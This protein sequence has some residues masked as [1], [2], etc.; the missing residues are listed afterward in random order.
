MDYSKTLQLPTT[1]FPMRASLP[2]REPVILA[3]WESENI[4]LRVQEKNRGR[5]KF[6]LH[7]GPP[8]A[9]GNIHLGT[10]LNK[11][12]KDIVVKFK[13]MDGFDAPY[14]PGWDTHGLPIEHAVI[15]ATGANPNE[16]GTVTFRQKCRD[17]ALK[18]RDIQ[19]EEFRR[20]GV[21]GDWDNPYMT[22]HPEFEA[23]QIEVFG[24]MAKK[25]YI[26]KGLK[27]VY[28]CA[29][30]ETALAEA[31]VEYGDR[32]S[33]SIFV[34]FAFPDG[35]RLI[36][37]ELPVSVII[38]TTTPW[39]LPANVAIALHPEQTYAFVR[40]D[41]EILMV[42]ADLVATVM[43]Q[44][45]ISTY[46]VVQTI[47][48]RE[49]EGMKA[50]HP[51]VDRDSLMVLG[52]HVTMDQGTGCVHTA[53]GHGLEDYDM[54]IRYDLPVIQPLD[55]K[56]RF[57]AEGG[58][59]A[60]LHYDKANKE[61][62]KELEARGALLHISFFNHSYPNCWRCKEPVIY[63][64][65]EQWFASVEGFRAQALESIEQVQ[66]IPSWGKERIRNMVADRLDWCISR[67][68]VWGVP[69]PI[70]YCRDCGKELINDVSIKAVADM[71]RIEGSDSWFAKEASE[72]LPAS[73]TC[74]GCGGRDFRKETD[75]MDVWFDSGS[76]HAAVLET[77]DALQWP[78]DLYLEGSD[79]HRGWFQS[80]LLTSVATRDRAPY[81][82]V[83][84]HGFVVDGEGRKM[85]KS[86]GN[87]I[88]P[89]EVIKE[90]GAD[91]L[92]LWVASSDFKTD[93][94][95]SKDILKQMAE[96]YRKIRN[97]A[98][99]ILGNLNDFDP[100]VDKVD[101]A[102][103]TELDRWAL[104]RLQKLIQRV[105]NAYRTY[106]YHIL[107]HGV[108]NFCTI[109]MSSL[110][111]DIL[112]DRLYAEK[113]DDV[114]RRASQTVMYEIVNA[115]VRLLAPV[116]TFTSE[117][118]WSYMPKE[119][120][121]PDRVQLCDWPAVNEQWIDEEMAASWDKFLEAR[122]VVSKALEL[123][124]KDKVIGQSLEAQVTLYLDGDWTSVANGFSTW[125]APV[126]IVSQVFVKKLEDAP[127]DAVTDESVTGVAVTISRA[128]GTKC[129]RCWNYREDIG[130]DPQHPTI[131]GRC[132]TV[133]K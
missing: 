118:I 66:W 81:L 122:E 96:V 107:Y 9:N 18:Y 1:E 98:R 2:D 101:Y 131:C 14:V 10:A 120:G 127:A 74:D 32:R 94:T 77:R 129:E 82:A 23:K 50:R 90:F 12:L 117:E 113:A 17:Y 38:W 80:S 13:S 124:R 125:L 61:I 42:A 24:E 79:Q 35:Q 115:L 114:R 69:I 37:T 116:L 68:R 121:M 128:D 63:R 33:P 89:Q 73:V 70:F 71:F 76:S 3:E 44:V 67:Q 64:A 102:H 60:G 105:T 93:I 22:L 86:L 133:L 106:D 39:T 99:F 110:Y 36:G 26:Y 46:D 97:T 108:H 54:G 111:L 30:C 87:V 55:S 19:R 100:N 7:D 47:S 34:S 49:L 15:K 72:I 126:F 52:E 43:A 4:Y 25:G 104:H 28:W 57:T 51:F 29:S 31:E 83:L 11:T 130:S 109:D 27:P 78:A 56:G 58:Q 5:K 65:T 45:G 41:K 8:Y 59:F 16:L 53:P 119:A 132:A 91:I 112:K 85:S 95:V 48:A 20:L 75:I 21:R 62:T 103:L 88:Y 40:T 6:V 123:A 92:R 84:T